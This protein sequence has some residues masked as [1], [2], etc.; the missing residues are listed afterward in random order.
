MNIAICDDESRV[1]TGIRNVLKEAFPGTEIREF[2]SGQEL[3]EAAG[4]DYLPDI[5]LMD[6]AMNGM[7][8]METARKLRE[9]YQV[10][11]IFV[12]GVKEQVFQAFDVGAFHYLLKPVEKEKLLS[13]MERAFAEVEKAGAKPKYMLVKVPGGHRRINAADILYAESDGRKVILHMKQEN[14]EFYEKMEELEQRL[15]E[16]FY[17]C[18]RGYLVSLSEVRGYDKAN[19][20]MSNGETVYLAKRKYSEFVQTYCRYLQE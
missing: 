17:R 6:I 20:R 18:H 2:V 12:T 15:G 13:V 5:V 4:Q 16:G 10:L 9:R 7:D 1:R 19:I 8:G 11:L 3:L 14:L